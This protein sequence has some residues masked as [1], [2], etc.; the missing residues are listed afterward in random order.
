MKKVIS[1]LL[2]II[3]MLIITLFPGVSFDGAKTGLLLWFQTVLPTLLPYMICSNVL[4]SFLQKR[5]GKQRLPACFAF[6]GLISGYP[7]GAKICAD[8][9]RYQQI[10]VATGQFLLPLCN[11][12]GPAFISGFIMQQS[13]ALTKGRHLYILCIYLPIMIYALFSYKILRTTF[14]SHKLVDDSPSSTIRSFDEAIMN[15]FLAITCLGGY[16]ILFSILSSLINKL[17]H[18]L[19]NTV[20]LLITGILEITNGINLLADS[21]LL[22]KYKIIISLVFLHFGGLS[23]LFQTKSMIHDSGISIRYYICAKIVITLLSCLMAMLLF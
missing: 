20:L 23:C 13:L 1:I 12:A 6:I 22:D 10:N 11:L 17:F 8:M 3:S 2:P 14:H 19:D 9:V 18:H 21:I 4:M 7:V 16:I 15:S 5:S